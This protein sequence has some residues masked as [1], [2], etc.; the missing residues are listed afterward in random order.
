MSA[1]FSQAFAEIPG[2]LFTLTV[3][4]A[5][6]LAAP[7][8]ESHSLRSRLPSLLYYVSGSIVGMTCIGLISSGWRELGVPTLLYVPA[9]GF[10]VIGDGL[11]I[12]VALIF[13]DFLR[14][15]EH[16]F[17]HRFIWSIHAL[18][19]SPTKL[20]AVSG[21]AHFGEKAFEFVLISVPLS[22]VSF[23]F[24]ATPFV[25]LAMRSMLVHYIHMPIDAGLG[26]LGYVFVDNRWHRI[27]HSIEPKHFDKNFG[28]MFSFWDRLFGTAY[29]PGR[30]WPDVGI[31]DSPP[32]RNIREVL[33]YPWLRNPAPQRLS[34]QRVVEHARAIRSVDP[35]ADPKLV[36]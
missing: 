4:T 9:S 1:F 13:Y 36:N 21:Y 14:Y 16:R 34:R 24:P 12:V 2:A 6:E 23:N 26:P 25:I 18:H 27:H 22:V 7:K 32:A 31:A 33:L 19:H 20:N 35:C 29:A 11:A 15:W 28:I 5:V 30:E 10:G 17:Q 3:A 8:M